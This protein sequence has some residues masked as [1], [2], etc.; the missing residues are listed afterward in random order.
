M[1]KPS[2]IRR[3]LGGT[4]AMKHQN[5]LIGLFAI[6]CLC[7]CTDNTSVSKQPSAADIEASKQRRL[8]EVEKLN[9]PEPAKARMRAQ[10]N[11]QSP[12]GTAASR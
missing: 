4:A 1:I 2:I 12:A 11:G 8:A 9:I 10:I 7:G 3:E 5:L 6:L